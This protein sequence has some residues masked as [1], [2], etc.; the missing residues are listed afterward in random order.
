MAQ[1]LRW[2]VTVISVSSL[3]TARPP[4]PSTVFKEGESSRTCRRQ[5]Q[6]AGLDD[7]DFRICGA[8]GPVL[9]AGLIF[10]GIDVI[11][12]YRPR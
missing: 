5:A 1:Y 2:C 8:I 3:L 12:G 9:K 10:T 4:V 7:D 6:A 11:G